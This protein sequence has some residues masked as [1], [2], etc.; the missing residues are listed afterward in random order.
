M[1]G[2]GMTRF[3]YALITVLLLALTSCASVELIAPYDA[4]IDQDITTLQTNTLTF[5]TNLQTTGPTAGDP[6]NYSPHIKFYNDTHVALTTLETR[7]AALSDNQ[8]TAAELAILSQQYDALQKQDQKIGLTKSDGLLQQANFN[9]TFRALLTLEVAKKSLSSS[10][11]T[12]S[13]STTPPKTT[14]TQ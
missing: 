4:I 8:D 3:H 9:R 12:S 11:A 2:G 6:S 7:V 13:T 1:K 5:L 14:T 10:D